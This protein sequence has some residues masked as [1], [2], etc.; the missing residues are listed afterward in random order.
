M[1]GL[2]KHNYSTK[3]PYPNENNSNSESKTNKKPCTIL[4]EDIVKFYGCCY[5][6]MYLTWLDRNYRL[7]KMWYSG[8]S[9]NETS[10]FLLCLT[11]GKKHSSLS[12]IILSGT[13]TAT[14]IQSNLVCH[15]AQGC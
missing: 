12:I 14:L 4:V 3:W 10:H 9:L 15:T 13:S 6:I 11:W 5:Y 7:N 1:S 2:T 8:S